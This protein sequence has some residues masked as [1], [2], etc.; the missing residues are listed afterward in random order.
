MAGGKIFGTSSEVRSLANV[1]QGCMSAIEETNEK[2]RTLLSNIEG[3]SSDAVYQQ[4]E[5]IVS[6]VAKAVSLG[7][8]PLESV[9]SSLNQYADLLER[10][11]K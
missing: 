11:G 8:E 1:T 3:S 5:E 6:Y 9:I 10:H 2:G 4:A 7:Q